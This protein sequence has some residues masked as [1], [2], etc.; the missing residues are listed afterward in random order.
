[1]RREK[2][3]QKEDDTPFFAGLCCGHLACSVTIA[4]VDAA[5]GEPAGRPNRRT[6]SPGRRLRGYGEGMEH[7]K[8]RINYLK[9]F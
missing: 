1:M 4:V 2:S 7:L 6:N 5:L 8:N 3:G 9:S